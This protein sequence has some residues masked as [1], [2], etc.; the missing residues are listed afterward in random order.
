[1]SVTPPFFTILTITLGSVPAR[2]ASVKVKQLPPPQVQ[3][4]SGSSSR[5]HSAYPNHRQS[6]LAVGVGSPALKRV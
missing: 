5:E 1:M 4:V 2:T 6:L 3:T